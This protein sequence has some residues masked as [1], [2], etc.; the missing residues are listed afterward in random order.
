MTEDGLEDSD[1]EYQEPVNR[2]PFKQTEPNSG[3]QKQNLRHQTVKMVDTRN[4]NDLIAKLLERIEKLEEAQQA[5]DRKGSTFKKDVECFS[6]HD[7]GHYARDCRKRTSSQPRKEQPALN[8]QGA[9][10]ESRGRSY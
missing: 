7:I 10:L 2:I 1:S 3:Q 6:C 8:M 4:Q 9:S 5:K